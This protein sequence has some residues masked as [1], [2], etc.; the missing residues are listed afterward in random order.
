MSL[1]VDVEIGPSLHWKNH[2][3]QCDV[4]DEVLIPIDKRFGDYCSIYYT[5]PCDHAHVDS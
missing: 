4:E 2:W 1:H 3:A 5:Y